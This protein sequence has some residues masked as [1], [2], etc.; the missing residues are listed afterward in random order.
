MEPITRRKALQLAGLI[1]GEAALLSIVGPRPAQAAA[2]VSAQIPTPYTLPFK[3]PP[4]ATPLKSNVPIAGSGFNSPYTPTGTFNGAIEP[5]G[6]TTRDVYQIDIQRSLVDIL[7]NGQKTQI[8]GYNG[9]APGPT[10]KVKKGV[11][12]LVRFR[13]TID[14]PDAFGNTVYTSVHLHGMPSLPPFDGWANDITLPGEDKDYYYPNSRPATH[15]YHDHGVHR[16]AYNAYSGLAAMYIVDDPNEV[17]GLPKNYGVDDFPLVLADKIFDAA[18]QLVF[19]EKLVANA[20]YHG[21]VILVN[22]VP[23]PTMTVEPKPYRFRVCSTGVSRAYDLFLSNGGTIQVIATDGGLL[24][25]A[26][27]TK[28]LRTGVSE[29]YEFVIDFSLYAGQTLELRNAGLKNHPDYLHTGKVMQFKVKSAIAG[30]TYYNKAAFNAALLK[31]RNDAFNFSSRITQLKNYGLSTAGSI[32]ERTMVFERKNGMWTIN[33][34]TWGDGVNPFEANPRS[35]GVEIWRL[36]NKAGGWNHPIHVHLVDF[37]MLSRTGGAS[38]G[39]RNYEQGFKDV[40]YL[41]ENEEI[42]FIAIFGPH[43]G[44][45]MFH[46]HNLPHEDDDMMRAFNVG[47][48]GIEP[49]GTDGTMR[50][51]GQGPYDALPRGRRAPL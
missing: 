48:N 39:V 2:Q 29:R 5:I 51:R 15:W 7:G 28:S 14:R 17:A 37:L 26:A 40:V 38:P 30:V 41:G 23:W 36:Q 13:N 10:I 22:G 46:C 44:K 18:G 45:Y 1:T 24:E 47:G 34:R 27:P 25:R 32:P 12:T 3:C 21:D 49:V 20:G 35:A 50:T 9:I 43:D 42:T 16:T 11:E 19:D 8:W 31:C 4:L 33:G 6:S